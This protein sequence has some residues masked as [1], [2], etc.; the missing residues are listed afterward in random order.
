[1]H[2]DMNNL[3]FSYIQKTKSITYLNAITAFQ[4]MQCFFQMKGQ[5]KEKRKWKEMKNK[6]KEAFFPT[7]TS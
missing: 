3:Q 5:K 2:K 7:M 4:C 6:P 1:M